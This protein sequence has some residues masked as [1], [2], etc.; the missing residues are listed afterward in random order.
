TTF[1]LMKS[2]D[3]ETTFGSLAKEV[4]VSVQGLYKVAFTLKQ[5]NATFLELL[6]TPILP[7]HLYANLSYSRVV[8]LGD[9]ISSVGTGPYRLDRQDGHVLILK[10]N[11]QYFKGTP[12]IPEI[13]I[14]VFSTYPLAEKA[15]LG[16]EVHVI[17]PIEVHDISRLERVAKTSS[18]VIIQPIVEANNTR[19][20]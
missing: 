4:E 18:H 2:G 14:E 8:E 19:M 6:L 10:A 9:S 5:V 12:K 17:S 1:E 20:L 3:T 7:D 11:Q 13:V 15:F 16:G